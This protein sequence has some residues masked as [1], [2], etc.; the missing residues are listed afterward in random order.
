MAWI[1]NSQAEVQR[2]PFADVARTIEI[3]GGS[4]ADSLFPV[5]LRTAAVVVLAMSGFLGIP[6]SRSDIAMFLSSFGA[7]HIQPC[8]DFLDPVDRYNRESQVSG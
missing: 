2:N 7:Q 8:L 6:R 5:R 4:F 3:F 1:L